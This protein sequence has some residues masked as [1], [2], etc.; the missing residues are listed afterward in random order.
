MVILNGSLKLQDDGKQGKNSV[1]MKMND[2]LKKSLKKIRP[3]RYA[4]H[5]PMDLKIIVGYRR[6]IRQ[7]EKL[8]IKTGK[9]FLKFKNKYFGQRCFIVGLGPSLKIEDLNLL[10]GEICFASNRVYQL[11]DKTDWRPVFY[12]TG[13]PTF[14]EIVREDLPVIS[15]ECKYVFLGL[16]HLYKY[17]EGMANKNNV[18]YYKTI[19]G[20]PFDGVRKEYGHFKEKLDLTAEIDSVGTITYEMIEMALFMGFSEI[21]LIGVDNNYIGGNNYAE[22]LKA[23]TGDE[24]ARMGMA[25]TNMEWTRGY[26][27]LQLIAEKKKR[28]IVNVTRG[29]NL[30]V[31]ERAAL[32]DILKWN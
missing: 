7:L 6:R 14:A 10:K 31:Y 21:Y 11:F 4:V 5:F 26:E 1:G 18:F 22:G 25:L 28:R 29:G 3:L 27:N 12:C 23:K 20:T 19:P 16:A 17:G 9:A 8:D 30:E 2:E 24:K 32:E 15:E 13:D